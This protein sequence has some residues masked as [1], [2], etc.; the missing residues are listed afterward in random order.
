MADA[1]PAAKKRA[2]SNAYT[3]WKKTLDKLAPK[4]KVV[5]KRLAEIAKLPDPNAISYQPS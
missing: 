5:K 1:A 3:R 2:T 4:V